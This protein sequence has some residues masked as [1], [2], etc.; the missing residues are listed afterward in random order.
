MLVPHDFV[1]IEVYGRFVQRKEL[2]LRRQ[3]GQRELIMDL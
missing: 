1:D 2:S 3:I